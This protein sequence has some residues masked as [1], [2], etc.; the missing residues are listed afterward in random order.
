MSLQKLMTNYAAYN[1][2]ANETLVNFIKT[3]PEETWVHEVP[4]RFNS[5]VKTLNH[6]LSAQEYWY[7]VITRTE[8]TAGRYYDA[9]PDPGE[10]FAS[11]VKHSQLLHE[12]ISNFSESDLLENILVESPWFTSNAPMYEYIQHL[13][14]HGTYHRGQIVTIGRNL[15]FADTPMTDYNFYTVYKSKLVLQEVH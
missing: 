14:N 2:W 10:V 13:F 11:L 3:K 4:S 5:I 9:N 6:I 15:N 8:H 1:A 12:A 7:A